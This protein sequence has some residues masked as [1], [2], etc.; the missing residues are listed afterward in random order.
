MELLIK[1][2]IRTL[3]GKLN[4]HYSTRASH[5]VNERFVEYIERELETLRF[6]LKQ[7]LAIRIAS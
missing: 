2:Q 4:S 7:I 1:E 3:K 6:Q 5:Q